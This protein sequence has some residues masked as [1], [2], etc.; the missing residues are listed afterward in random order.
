M[1]RAI[2]VDD[3]PVILNKLTS[4]LQGNKHIQLIGA[5]ADP[6]AA[7]RDIAEAAPDCAFLD[8]E[9]PGLNGIELAERILSIAPDTEIVFLTAYN[10]YASQA[11]D[12][13]AIDYLLKPIRPERLERTVSRLLKIMDAKPKLQESNCKIRCFGMLEVTM[14]NIAIKWGRSRVRELLAYLLEHEGRWLTKYRLCEELWSGYSPELALSYLQTCLYALRKSLRQAG[15]EQIEIHYSNDRYVLTV[16]DAHWDIRQFDK[17]YEVFMKSGS[18]EA[19]RQALS[20]CRGE[21]LEGEDWLWSDVIREEYICKF[22]R[23]KAA[24]SG[25]TKLRS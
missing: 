1:L 22:D 19:A 2:L 13:N 24:V 6:L 14:D 9:M 11:F 4:I 17:E 8:I 23:L 7:L 20:C 3:E 16:K 21:Y 15:C 5:Y 18:V 10:H 12:V 25:G